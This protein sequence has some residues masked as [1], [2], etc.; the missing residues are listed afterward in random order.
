MGIDIFPLIHNLKACNNGG[1]GSSGTGPT[2]P[3]GPGGG[4]K[5]PTGP[6]GSSGLPGPPGPQGP[7]GPAGGP[8]GPTGP[9]GGYYLEPYIQYDSGNIIITTNLVVTGTVTADSYITTS[10]ER[11]KSHIK[12][13]EPDVGYETI[14]KFR[15]VFYD[16]AIGS[17]NNGITTSKEYGFIAQEIEQIENSLVFDAAIKGVNYNGIIPILVSAIQKSQ[18]RIEYLEA[19]LGRGDR[20][21]AAPKAC[22]RSPLPPSDD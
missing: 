17:C 2:G 13:L 14:K 19:Q 9:T 20:A 12:T 10:D 7:P 21:S 18:E 8:T 22:A 5:G 16:K 11:I 4:G 1:G 3:T 15:P 6:T